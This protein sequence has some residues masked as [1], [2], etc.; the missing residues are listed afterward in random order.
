MRPDVNV[1]LYDFHNTKGNEMV[2]LNEDDTYTVL[3]N[4]RLDYESAQKAYIH[5][6][7]HIDNHDF[8]KADVQEIEYQAHLAG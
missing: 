5:A 3:I 8:E 7:R 2:C 6:L 4:S 1:F